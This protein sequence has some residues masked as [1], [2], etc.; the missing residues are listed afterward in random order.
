V[1]KRRQVK[2]NIPVV[3]T[4]KVA[5]A[6]LD[7]GGGGGSGEL[8]PIGPAPLIDGGGSSENRLGGGDGAGFGE[9]EGT[10]GSAGGKTT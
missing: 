7:G 4:T 3:L 5:E 1:R 10:T 2:K 9:G 6:T 8:G